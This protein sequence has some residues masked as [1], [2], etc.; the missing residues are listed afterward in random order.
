MLRCSLPV[1]LKPRPQ[2]LVNRS[3][4]SA[5]L[6]IAAVAFA[7]AAQAQTQIAALYTLLNTALAFADAAQAQATGS[8]E[9]QLSQRVATHCSLAVADA[10]QV[11]AQIAALCMLLNTTLAF[12]DASQAQAPWSGKSQP[13]HREATHCSGGL[14]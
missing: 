7:D 12:A 9:S 10:A 5:W 4:L 13:S 2:G 6:F 14:C 8:G 1:R 3:P 11:Q